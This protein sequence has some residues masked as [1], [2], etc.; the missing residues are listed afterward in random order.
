MEAGSDGRILLCDEKTALGIDL[1]ADFTA[2]H[3]RGIGGLM[4][5]FGLPYKTELG[6]EA[7]KVTTVPVGL[8]HQ[9]KGNS[10]LLIYDPHL[11]FN[12]KNN[13]EETIQSL[14]ENDL[15]VTR[16]N[17]ERGFVGAWSKDSFGINVDTRTNPD[18]AKELYN[19]LIAKDVVITMRA[20]KFIANRGLTL[21][22]YS[23]I[24][25]EEK[26]K[27]REE[28][29]R[30]RELQK[31]MEELEKKSG[32]I[33]LLRDKKKEY[34][35]LHVKRLD[36]QGQACWWLNPYDQD[37]YYCGWFSTKDLIDWANDKGE[38]VMPKTRQRISK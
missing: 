22:I 23:R 1:G 16:H 25:D 24:P 37:K 13:P 11:L 7:L 18:I 21:L 32:V 17:P 19:A 33:E 29:K 5:A 14:M 9:E 10:S 31:F 4:K 3:E 35:Y 26:I 27:F 34:F 15:S 30:G 12:M 20:G 38:V 2:E 28:D 36:G 6:Y 8:W